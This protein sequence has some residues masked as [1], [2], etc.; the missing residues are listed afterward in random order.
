[1]AWIGSLLLGRVE[2]EAV[3]DRQRYDEDAE[4]RKGSG[5]AK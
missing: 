4:G 5:R 3:R 1:M 2:E